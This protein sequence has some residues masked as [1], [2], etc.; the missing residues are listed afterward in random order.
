MY[1]MPKPGKYGLSR[2]TAIQFITT[3]GNFHGPYGSIVA[4]A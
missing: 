2:I 1:T 3:Q 4:N